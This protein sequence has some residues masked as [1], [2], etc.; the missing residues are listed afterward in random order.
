MANAHRAIK[1]KPETPGEVQPASDCTD[2]G[3]PRFA[4]YVRR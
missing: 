4:A 3:L 1:D 2:A